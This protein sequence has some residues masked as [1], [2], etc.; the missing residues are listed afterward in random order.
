MLYFVKNPRWMQ[1]LFPRQTW[2]MG[3]EEKKLYLTFDDGPHPDH[4]GF[5]LDELKKYDARA[6]FFCIGKNVN[7]YKEMYQRIREEGHS[8]GNHTMNHLNGSKTPDD[9]YIKDIAAAAELIETDLFRPPYGRIKAFQRKLLT[10]GNRP[11]R[12]IMW[13]VLSG[14]FDPG[15]STQRCLENVLLKTGNGSIIVFHD[16]EKASE[17]LRIVLPAVL[18]NLNE[19]GF[20]FERIPMGDA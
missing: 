8:V 18:K 5:V 10:E 6:T 3:R 11:F 13:T 20:C 15:I 16:S 4:T 19:R 12:I 14:D 9:I 1:R 2:E 17:K 7:L